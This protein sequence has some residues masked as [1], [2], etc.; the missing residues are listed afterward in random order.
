M[1]TALL[2]PA[3]PATVAE[4]EKQ[5][6]YLLDALKVATSSAGEHRLFRWGKLN[7]LFPSRVGP[8]AVAARFALSQGL[9]EHVRTEA[10]GRLVV[11]WVRSLPK[12]VEYLHDHDSPKAVLRELQ[13]VIGETRAGVPVWM[14][15]ARD[16]A[17]QLSLRFDHTAREMMKRLDALSERVDAALQR[18]ACATPTLG[19]GMT[20][21]VP[22]ANAVL[23]DLDWRAAGDSPRPATLS[24]VFQVANGSD[25]NLS[26]FGFHEGIRKLCDGGLLT[27]VAAPV[28]DIDE[29]EYALE[30][31][32][33]MM[34]LV[35]R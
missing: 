13:E 22:W 32:G 19:Q 14:A 15:Q 6:E 20:R 28:E 18:V 4:L 9:L 8:S 29:P 26:V 7:G 25:A 5:S 2:T 21:L 23:A 10:K 17:A 31:G 1:E 35:Q 34:W 30:I 12:A 27:L 11:E 3:A 16:E 24:E 33:Q